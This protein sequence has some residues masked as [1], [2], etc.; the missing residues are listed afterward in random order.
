MKLIILA[1]GG[2]TRLWPYSRQDYPK[3]FLHF[4]DKE[5]LLEKTLKRFSNVS[6]ITE[7]VI[8]TNSKYAHLVE[9]QIAKANPTYKVM[10]LIEPFAKNTAPAVALAIK[11]FQEKYN[12]NEDENV[13]IIPSDHIIYP[14][15][16]FISY[17]EKLL[18][19]NEKDLIVTFG[20]VPK[21][22]ETGF[23]YIKVDK[24]IND[25]LFD[26]EKFIEKPNKKNAG[27]LIEEKKSFWNAGIFLFS[28][29]RFLRELKTHSNE[30]FKLLNGTYKEV[31]NNF[32]K[33]PS[34]SID[35]AIMEKTK[36]ICVC[37]LN[38]SWSDVGSWDGVYDVLKKDKNQNV[39]IGN[40]LDLD[41]KN[42]LIIGSKR[43]ISTI[44][45][46]DILVVETD[47]A[48][49]LAKKG[50]SQKVKELMSF[51]KMKNQNSLLFKNKN[52][53]P[54]NSLKKGK[55]F[56]I[57]HFSIEK[58]FFKESSLNIQS[59][60]SILSGFA[61]F[62]IDGKKQ[63]FD[64]NNSIKV[65]KKAKIMIEN[66]GDEPLEVLEVMIKKQKVKT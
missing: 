42:S 10:C 27:K 62:Y 58:D 31:F 20:I 11:Y 35:Y 55:N 2:G 29:K 43:L 57:N 25:L 14:E 54:K 3:Q 37:P 64:E 28:I 50:S 21:K 8:V 63:V 12:S 39:K 53:K 60:Y 26:V 56:D 41:T 65:S 40:V 23:G 30:I 1:G 46:E 45:L 36:N 44:D 9:K 66:I 33:M 19:Q 49:F 16:V 24:K 6:F 47:D 61:N 34:I 52:T 22:A 13:L 17:I 5:S 7:A 59:Q 38:I 4:G 32:Y 48:I 51:M 15:D 18:A